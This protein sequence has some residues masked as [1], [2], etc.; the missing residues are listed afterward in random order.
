MPTV[1]EQFQK[2]R[3]L[4]EHM[5]SQVSKD[6]KNRRVAPRLPVRMSMTVSLLGSHGVTSVEVYSRNFSISG[7][8]FVSRR[9]FRTDERIAIVLT[10]PN[11]T[12][13]QILAR[14][15][16]GRYIRN[17]MYE[18]GSEFLDFVSNPKNSE[19][20]PPHWLHG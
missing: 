14:V 7:F 1:A 3:E 10:F 6:A 20:F 8:G 19:T 17:G 13:K 12:I 4:L 9:L 2:V 15:T 16:F 18:M 11:Q 5:D